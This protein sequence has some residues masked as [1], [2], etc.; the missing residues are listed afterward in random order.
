MK[1]PY[2]K[3]EMVLGIIRGGRDPIKWVPKKEE[4]VILS[5]IIKRIIILDFMDSKVEGHYCSEC[6]KI[7]IDVAK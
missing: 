3:N 6:N 2:C 5:A 7:T 4:G 1:C